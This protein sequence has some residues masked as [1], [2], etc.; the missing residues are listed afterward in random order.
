MIF[1]RISLF[2]D[3]DDEKYDDEEA[4]T[5]DDDYIDANKVQSSLTPI[6][7]ALDTVRFTTAK[8]FF[9]KHQ[10]LHAEQ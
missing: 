1:Q 9:T 3:I 4:S 2:N 10:Q 7:N 5:S 6:N 8:Y